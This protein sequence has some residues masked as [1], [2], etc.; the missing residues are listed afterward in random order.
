MPPT[1]YDVR[2]RILSEVHILRDA[3]ARLGNRTD[4]RHLQ[5]RVHV[6]VDQATNYLGASDL[7]VVTDFMS[8]A[9]DQIV[10]S[11]GFGAWEETRR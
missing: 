8:T 9:H 3:L 5:R 6:L 1:D 7:A 4:A 10:R 11:F 2:T